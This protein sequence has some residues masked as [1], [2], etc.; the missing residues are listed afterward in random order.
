[1]SAVFEQVMSA[2]GMGLTAFGLGFIVVTIGIMTFEVVH[3]FV[4]GRED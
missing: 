3:Y 4:K 2:V 1:M